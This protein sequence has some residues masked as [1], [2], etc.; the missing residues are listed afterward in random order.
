MVR[1]R[2]LL[3]DDYPRLIVA[4][5]RLLGDHAC[6]VVGTAMDGVQLLEE[7]VRLQPDIILLDLFMPKMNGLDA[8]RELARL[9]PRAKIV[10]VTADADPDIRQ[11]ALAVGAFAV[12]DK[13]AIVTDL[14]P[15]IAA[16]CGGQDG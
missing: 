4:I 16:A 10:V 7:A 12:V 6:E 3:A 1:P 5:D 15:A 9:L 8:C 13:L 14:L 11:A 2:I